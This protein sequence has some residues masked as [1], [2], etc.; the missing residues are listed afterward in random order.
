MQ[1][2]MACIGVRPQ[3]AGNGGSAVREMEQVLSLRRLSFYRKAYRLLGNAA[4]AEDAVQDALLSAY[5]H[6][7]QFRGQSQMSTWLTSIVTNAARMQLRKRPRQFHVSLDEPFGE[8]P[9]YSVLD[10]LADCGPSPEVRCSSSEISAGLKQV[11]GQLSPT[12]RRTFQLRDLD[13]LST[14]EVARMLAVPQ[15]T[16]KARLARAR[17]R[18]RQLMSR[19]VDAPRPRSAGRSEFTEAQTS[20]D[21]VRI[22]KTPSAE[23]RAQKTRAA[24][25]Q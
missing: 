17:K 10:R 23:A 4:D 12:L 25:V 1:E 5:T 2:A 24:K 22:W 6:L 19:M 15:G 9:E 11:I 14:D 18:L 20:L 21:D 7:N 8:D 13:G 3:F 16:V